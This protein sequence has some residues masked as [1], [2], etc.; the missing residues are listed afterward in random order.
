MVFL[1]LKSRN[2]ATIVLM[3]PIG[4]DGLRKGASLKSLSW[5]KALNLWLVRE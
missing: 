5:K 1:R 4:F 2:F 3:A